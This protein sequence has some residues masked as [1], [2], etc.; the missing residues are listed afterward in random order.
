M[1]DDEAT[2]YLQRTGTS[3]ASSDVP[4]VSESDQEW[5]ALSPLHV[6][7]ADTRPGERPARTRTGS[8]SEL[9]LCDTHGGRQKHEIC[10]NATPALD[11]A[12][13]YGRGGVRLIRKRLRREDGGA[14]DPACVAPRLVLNQILGAAHAGDTVPQHSERTGIRAGPSSAF[15]VRIGYHACVQIEPDG[16]ARALAFQTGTYSNT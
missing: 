12:L 3:N 11:A 6:R 13:F 5:Y 9:W 15:L 2:P 10:E 16:L 8:G 14:N 4:S 7:A 1:C